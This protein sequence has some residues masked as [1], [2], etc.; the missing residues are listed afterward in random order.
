MY[1]RNFKLSGKFS[2][3]FGVVLALLVL[4]AGWSIMGIGTIITDAEKIITADGLRTEIREIKMAHM[5]WAARVKDFLMD[6]QIAELN[7]ATDPTKCRF[8]TWYYGEARKQAEIELPELAS[9]LARIEEPHR[10]MHEA[11]KVLGSLP[12][13][14]ESKLSTASDTGHVAVVAGNDEQQVVYENQVVPAMDQVQRLFDEIIDTID[15]HT[16]SDEEMLADANKTRMGVV[17]V[18]VVALLLGIGLAVVIARSI[19]G[20][21]RDSCAMILDLEKGR[22]DRRLN[23]QRGDEIGLMANAMDAFADNLSNEVLGAFDSLASGDFT[24]QAEGLIREPLAKANAALCDLVHQLQVSGEQ[25]ASGAMQISSA[26]EHLSQGAT[27]SAS[28]IEEISASMMEM[29]AQT[30]QTAGSAAQASK[31]AEQVKQAAEKGSQRM[32]QMV[33]AMSDIDE[34]GQDISRIIKVIDEIA[35]QTNLLALNA[36]VEAA[37]AGQHGKGFAVVAEEVRSLA[38]RSAQAARETTG[39]IEKSVQKTQHGNQIAGETEKALMEILDGV[40]RVSGLVGEIA[41]ASNEQAEGIGQVNQG[42]GQIDQVTQANTANSEESAASAEEL[43]GQAEEMHRMLNRFKVANSAHHTA[44]V[45]LTKKLE[46]GVVRPFPAKG[47]IV[48]AAMALPEPEPAIALD[49]SE[50]GRF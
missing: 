40:E 2:L 50:F 42:L 30:Q 36:A 35:F 8:G 19:V 29:A 5:E 41:V 23:M 45:S 47:K 43:S 25:I 7:V 9:V 14:G 4:L 31:M 17:L 44:A 33:R 21:L 49:D 6:A 26:A 22:L 48:R 46:R 28:A 18:T 3:G 39:L 10:K 16:I 15:K 13:R 12:V 38:T 11:A 27:E 24:F 32:E 1:W 37:R 34:A 20:P